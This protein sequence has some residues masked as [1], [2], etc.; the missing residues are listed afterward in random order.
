L[1]IAPVIGL[2]MRA[3]C[4]KARSKP[5]RRSARCSPLASCGGAGFVSKPVVNPD[6]SESSPALPFA[7]LSGSCLL[8]DDPSSRGLAR[9]PSVAIFFVG[10]L[11]HPQ[12]GFADNR[13][14]QA[15]R[16]RLRLKR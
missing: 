15:L 11:L 12:I 1:R 7:G 5:P 3:S 8:D 9:L 13:T 10:L 2:A 6:W 4:L 14:P 16:P